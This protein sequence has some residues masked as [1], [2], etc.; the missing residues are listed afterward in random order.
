MLRYFTVFG[1][2]F[3]TL[4]LI[5]AQNNNQDEESMTLRPGQVLKLA[6]TAQ[7]D[8]DI[9]SAIDY[10][11]IYEELNPGRP[12]VQAA[13]G[14]L[15]LKEKNYR[16][17]Q[18][19]LF[20]AYNLDPKNNIMDLFYYAECLKTL[21][22]YTEAKQ[23]F[24][25][26]ISI[27][28]K[29]KD[30]KEE[31]K[32]AKNHIEGIASAELWLSMPNN[33]IV[34]HI[35]K[36]VNKPHI[37][38]SPIPYEDDKLI[39][40]SLAEDEVKYY[41]PNK[42]ELPVRK[43]YLAQRKG[44]EWKNLGEF[45]EVINGININTGNG[46]FSGDKKRF[47]FTRC[48]KDYSNKV[49]CKIFVS[50]LENNIWQEPQELPEQI[51]QAGS[52]NTMPSVGVSRMNTDI[53]YFVSDRKNGQ[54]GLD[55]W[56]TFYDSKRKE[57]K[58]PKN[59]G[60][61]INTPADEITPYYNI[62]T[63]TLY[64]SSNG[65]PGMGGFDVFKSFGEGKNF[66][67]ALNLEY[68]TNS[69]FDD[70]Y[71]VLEDNRQR[72]FFSSNRNGGYSLRHENCCDDI[73]EF[74]NK[75]YINIAVT[76]KIFGITDS[77]FFKTIEKE[78]Q[79]EMALSLNVLERSDD[80]ELLYD[81]QVS[82]FMIDKNNGKELF[83]K[84]D[85]TTPGYYFFNLEQG[86]D[87]FISV[88]DYNKKEKRLP[89]TTKNITI[90]DTLVL[91]AIII[92]T[93]PEQSFIVKNIYYEFAKSNLTTDAQKTIDNTVFK[94]LQAYPNI[95]IEISSH[96]DSIDSE[97]FNMKLS[98]DRAQSVVDYLIKKGIEPERLVA[99]GYGKNFPIAPNTNPDGSDNPEGRQKNRRTEFKVIG[100]LN[101]EEEIIYED[102]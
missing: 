67:G 65:H 33:I 31:V 79:Q 86:F 74:I 20:D 71:F 34:K 87:Y 38:F 13:L 11:K 59:C 47:Y 81:Y 96:T 29:N 44:E 69:S 60:K 80:I 68:P 4:N 40:A 18:K 51:N 7:K 102:Y 22:E 16:E 93:L 95:I 63:K 56:F 78:Y 30:L 58:E 24:N 53:L 75:D 41:D 82:L 92:N 42:D 26:F 48:S 37:D 64:F 36:E 23:Y 15:Y 1:F 55:I 54:G 72:G 52:T 77:S 97:E 101:N 94:I 14:Q 43:F 3:F 5:F 70:L 39:W 27:A 19:Y 73:Y 21:G 28:R 98:Q 50:N 45:E 12:K 76:G 100:Q 6:K 9:F 49:I 32:L 8:G 2:L 66:D 89:F 46:A 17:A 57:W 35:G 62:E 61:R 85:F 83:V 90:S 25:Q 84:N 91:D 88:K 99:K 10:Y